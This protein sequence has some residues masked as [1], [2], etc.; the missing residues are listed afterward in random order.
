MAFAPEDLNTIDAALASGVRRVTF[1]DGRTTEYHGPA[2]L[3]QARQMI[4]AELA[5]A[6]N[7]AAGR[8]RKR[9][10]RYGTGL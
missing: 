4:V 5:K 6:D 8:P 3:L 2:E 7:A 10:A 1:A 9:F